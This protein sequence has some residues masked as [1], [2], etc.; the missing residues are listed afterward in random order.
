MKVQFQVFRGT[1]TS[2]EA[3]FH[4]AAQFAS[5]LGPERLISISHSE[6]E[7]DGVVTVWYWE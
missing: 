6:D 5:A 7:N 4:E 1:W 2:F 3:L